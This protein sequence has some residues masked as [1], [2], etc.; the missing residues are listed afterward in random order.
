MSLNFTIT[1]GNDSFDADKATALSYYIERS[2]VSETMS[3]DTFSF[4]VEAPGTDFSAYHYGDEI[5]F[6][7]GG[8]VRG[9]FY[10][11]SVKQL[12]P[13]RYAVECVSAVGLM[14]TAIH[15][16]GI[17]R[18]I[19]TGA[20]I[21]DILGASPIDIVSD[22]YTYSGIVTY[23][24]DAE[25]ANVPLYGYLK[26]QYAR[27]AL[28]QVLFATG[29][30]LMKNASGDVYFK[31]PRVGTAAPISDDDVYVG[32]SIDDLTP[33]TVVKVAEHMFYAFAGDVERILFDNT[34]GSGEAIRKEIVFDA[35]MHDLAVTGTLTIEDSGVNYAVITGTGVLSGKE[36]THTKRVLSYPT[37]QSGPENVISIEDATL[38]S[39]VNS[40]NTARR[41]VSYYAVPQL[42]TRDIV[43]DNQMPGDYVSVKTPVGT[44]VS[45]TIK[46]LSVTVS[47]TDKATA[48]I[49]PGFYP[50]YFG[51]NFEHFILLTE[52]GSITVPPDVTEMRVLISGGGEGGKGG[53]RGTTGA[54]NGDTLNNRHINPGGAPGEPGSPG[55]LLTVDLSVTPGDTITA[56]IGG[57]GAGGAE[58]TAGAAGGDSTITVN[59]TTYSSADGAVPQ[60]GVVNLLTGDI[61]SL[62]GDEGV[63]GAPGGNQG[64]GNYGGDITYD[65]VTNHGGEGCNQVSTPSGYQSAAAG[66]G[67][68][69][70]G[71]DGGNAYG[72]GMSLNSHPGN[73][74][75]PADADDATIPGSGGHA[76]HGGGGAGMS[77]PFYEYVYGIPEGY[78]EWE[79][80]ANSFGTPGPGGKAGDGA[81]GYVLAYY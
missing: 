78:W 10:F 12:K 57:G 42:L 74:A 18:G 34:D 44:V 69:A 63:A 59:G 53:K 3:A 48:A 14:Q 15:K 65:G 72:D 73:G 5:V 13:S 20:L 1:K 64:S 26:Y 80:W 21:A 19:T 76:G 9:K 4:E 46:S 70:V 37:G 60:N 43:L 54:D 27:E 62:K 36:Y 22:P 71:T 41:V 17:Y 7:E 58:D 50:Q 24:I 40:G 66:G 16:G 61:Y 81:P 49:L 33:A 39:V 6:T 47:G 25:V 35:P 75:T 68:A 38:V 67:G 11:K 29:A 56:V 55:K 23:Q 45:G 77:M 2:P 31:Y 51:N 8:A 79:F 52:S 30:G 32:G 28:L